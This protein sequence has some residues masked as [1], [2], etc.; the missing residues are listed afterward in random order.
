MCMLF[1]FLV[2]LV[3]LYMQFC[4]GS[5]VVQ[6]NDDFSAVKYRDIMKAELDDLSAK[7]T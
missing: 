7:T 6:Y 2:K 3:L 4:K 5:V 1:V